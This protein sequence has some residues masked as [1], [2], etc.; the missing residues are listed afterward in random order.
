MS[1]VFSV[2][3]TANYYV[4]FV[5]QNVAAADDPDQPG[6]A[7]TADQVPDQPGIAAADDPVDDS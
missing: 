3:V 6:F 1:Q 2:F 5:K 4:P 7:A